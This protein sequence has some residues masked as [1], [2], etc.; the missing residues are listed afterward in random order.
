M[1]YILEVLSS[2]AFLAFM[3]T[4]HHTFLIPSWDLVHFDA[5]GSLAGSS[6]GVNGGYSADS[7]AAS[8]GGVLDGI[9]GLEGG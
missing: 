9:W 4:S 3:G 1:E 7:D 2:S 8:W 6:A 5:N